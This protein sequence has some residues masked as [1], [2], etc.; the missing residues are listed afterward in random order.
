MAIQQEMANIIKE[1]TKKDINW[2]K[3]NIG[4]FI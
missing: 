1:L 4:L 3:K 2:N